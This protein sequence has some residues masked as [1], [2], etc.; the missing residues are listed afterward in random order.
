M[1]NRFSRLA[2]THRPL[3]PNFTLDPYSTVPIPQKKAEKEDILP[4]S[5]VETPPTLVIITSFSF[6]TSY[7]CRRSSMHT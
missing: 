1:N 7:Q 6:V 4:R 3:D 5:M 2:P